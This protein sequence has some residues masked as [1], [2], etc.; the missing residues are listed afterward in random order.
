MIGIITQLQRKQAIEGAFSAVIM[1][2]FLI[3]GVTG[4]APNQNHEN[5]LKKCLRAH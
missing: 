5:T 4:T 3:K 1:I 2:T